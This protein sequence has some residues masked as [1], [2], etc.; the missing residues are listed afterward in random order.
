MNK[1]VEDDNQEGGEQCDS[2]GRTDAAL[3]ILR[4][5]RWQESREDSKKSLELSRVVY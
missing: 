5:Q 3:S 4:C 1:V 2:R